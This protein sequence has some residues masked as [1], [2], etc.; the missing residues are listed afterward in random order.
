MKRTNC[1]QRKWKGWGCGAEY[2]N[3]K[4]VLQRL[5]TFLSKL[6]MNDSEALL[7]AVSDWCDEI[8]GGVG[9]SEEFDICILYTPV[10][11]THV[12]FSSVTETLR[13]RGCRWTI[14]W[15]MKSRI[16]IRAF[17]LQASFGSACLQTRSIDEC[18]WMS[19]PTTSRTCSRKFCQERA[20]DI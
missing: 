4:R 16:L 3:E 19:R 7:S 1:T 6:D 5:G 15:V 17:K 9:S 13:N 18:K 14:L 20:E 2:C 11:M 12:N 8:V 10:G